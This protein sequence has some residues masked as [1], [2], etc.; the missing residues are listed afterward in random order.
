MS[1][2][3]RTIVYIDGFNFYFG[4]LKNTPYKWLNLQSL[5]CD[6]FKERNDIVAIKYYTA[7]VSPTHSNPNV[8]NRQDAYLRALKETCPIVTI[9]YGHFLRHKVSMENAQ[10]PPSICR[11]WKNE[12]KG[13][14]VN[15]AVHLVNDAWK[16][17][18]ETA[19]IVSNDSDL[20]EALRIV[21]QEHQKTVG[22]VTPGAPKR[23]TSRQLLHFADFVTPIRSTALRNHQLPDL[24]PGTSITKPTTWK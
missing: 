19:I 18:F 11:V 22:L 6:V 4:S 24:I 21:K 9:H 20:T 7:R 1:S 14:D 12:E 5:F 3:T 17:R 10:P 15:I 16:G 13:S 2:L 23:K 8:S